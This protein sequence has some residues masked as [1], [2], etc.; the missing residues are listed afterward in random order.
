MPPAP[1]SGPY[2]APGPYGPVG[3]SGW[4]LG[5]AFSFG[6]S[7]FRANAGAAVIATL[8]T[9]VVVGA[10]S[11]V[12]AG[13]TFAGGDSAFLAFV[14]RAVQSGL[15]GL[16]L[17][18]LVG[19]FAQAALPTTE[20]Q[21]FTLDRFLDLGRLGP[22]AVAGAIVGAASFVGTLLC[23]IPG[24]IAT[25]LLSYAAYF[26]VDQGLEPVAAAKASVDLCRRNL[27]TTIVWAI[28]GGIAAGVGVCACGV[29]LLV[30]VPIVLFGTAYTYRTLTGRP[31]A[32]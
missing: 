21:P 5:T 30:T 26:V 7:R 16:A 1:P 2:G 4:D 12:G 3:G 10:F 9:L 14:L 22:L 19:L 28:L 15:S 32:I 31:V 13:L 17:T 20:G 23:V 6:W 24:V 18:V 11:G 25:Y 27:G 29:G 8:I